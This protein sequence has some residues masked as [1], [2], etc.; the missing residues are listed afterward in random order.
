M[1]LTRTKKITRLLHMFVFT[2]LCGYQCSLFSRANKN[3]NSSKLLI[4]IKFYTFIY[5]NT[6]HSSQKATYCVKYYF[7]NPVLP[8][9]CFFYFH[10]F[11]ILF[12]ISANLL[13]FAA[14]AWAMVPK[15]NIKLYFI[16]FIT[17]F[18][19]FYIFVCFIQAMSIIL[20][21]ILCHTVPLF[22][23]WK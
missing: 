2:S 7:P 23:K 9:L 3:N 17:S 14:F 22:G 5:Q 16:F 19:I 18:F 6:T 21:F 13:V 1:F 10:I 15:I 4:H 20:F 11:Y 12:I 8:L